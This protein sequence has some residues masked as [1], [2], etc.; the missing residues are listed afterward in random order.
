[1]NE[2]NRERKSRSVAT[3]PDTFQPPFL[4]AEKRFPDY[5]RGAPSVGAYEIKS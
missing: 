1:M 4:M 5:K 2:L 3:T